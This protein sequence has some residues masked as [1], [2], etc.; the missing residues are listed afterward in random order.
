MPQD[1]QLAL[2]RAVWQF[3]SQFCETIGAPA[4]LPPPSVTAID[5][6]D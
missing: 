2:E 1:I 3:H 6:L 4:G 5:D